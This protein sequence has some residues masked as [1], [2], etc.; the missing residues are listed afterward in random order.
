VV[1]DEGNVIVLL[2]NRQL[3]KQLFPKEVIEE[4]IVIVGKLV[5]LLNIASGNVVKIV[6]VKLTL[7]K[8]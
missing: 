5:Q 4:G 1:I 3:S 7:V 8:E 6:E 2:S